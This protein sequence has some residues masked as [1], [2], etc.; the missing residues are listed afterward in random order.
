MVEA[1]AI[2]PA[3]RRQGLGHCRQAQSPAVIPSKAT[4]Q[5]AELCSQH[6]GRPLSNVLNSTHELNPH[7]PHVSGTAGEVKA[8][9]VDHL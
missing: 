6:T 7:V 1:N 3:A 5:A 8:D 4:N 9:E 2:D